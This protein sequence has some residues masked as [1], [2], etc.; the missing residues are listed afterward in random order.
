MSRIISVLLSFAFASAVAAA[1]EPEVPH[2]HDDQHQ[3]SDEAGAT[4]KGQLTIPRVL[5]AE[6]EQL[7]ARLKTFVALDG[8]IGD[9]AKAVAEV[10]R[11][12]FLRENEIAMPVLDLLDELAEGKEIDP[13]RR[14]RAIELSEALAAEQ[15]RM[16]VEHRQ[17]VSALEELRSA[18]R[19]AE[20]Q[21]AVT[22]ADELIAHARYEEEVLYPAAILVGRY[23]RLQQ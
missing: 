8:P 22:F 6:H 23:L 10:L 18:A 20:Q 14:E 15:Q 7:H 3:P 21:D 13:Q 17:I 1:T 2:E 16:L 9:A 5:L 4:Q 12:H 19:D 11:P